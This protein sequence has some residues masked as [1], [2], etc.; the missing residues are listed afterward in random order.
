MKRCPQCGREY[1][2]TMSYCLDDGSE[3]LYGPAPVADQK[4]AILSAFDASENATSIFGGAVAAKRN[5]ENSIAV[6]PFAH[7]SSDPDDEYFCDGLAEELLNAL[8]KIDELKVAARTSAFSF[9]GKNVAIAEIARKLGVTSILEGSVRKN[10]DKLRITVQLVNAADGYH[11]WSER[12]DREMKDIFAVQDEIALTVVDALKLK[13]VG[14]ER[15]AVLKRHTVDPEAYEMYLRGR[16]HWNKRDAASLKKAVEY[17]RAAATRD[18][19][20]ALAFVGLADCYLLLPYV[21]PASITESLS[22]AAVYAR[23]ALEIDDS[24]GEAH[25]SMA[26]VHAFAWDW[27]AAEKEFRRGIELAPNYPSAKQWYGCHA[28]V[29]GR[30]DEA[31]SM[32]K[33]AQE[34]DPLSLIVMANLAEVYLKRGDVDA[35]E[36]QC[37]LAIDTDANWYYARQILSLVMLQQGRTD[38]AR[39]EAEK[40]VAQSERLNTP[41]GMLGFIHARTGKLDEAKLILAE[42]TDLYAA[43]R[44]TASDIARVYVGMGDNDQAFAWLNR[45]FESRNSLMP[46]YLD[47]PPLDLLRNDQRFDDLMKGIGLTDKGT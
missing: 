25:N 34:L 41:L 30:L 22:E 9:K 15:E 29:T 39:I 10:G 6:L 17:F 23:R 3:L 46:E 35:A 42:L 31:V 32:L 45:D 36:A 33:R 13:L 1:D 4:T 7:L 47:F 19:G 40:S 2:V 5:A 37:R 38:D 12:Y 21:D 27:D 26:L 14:R 18:H 20:F 8:T 43:G 11:I 16:F 44:A 28:R 24:L